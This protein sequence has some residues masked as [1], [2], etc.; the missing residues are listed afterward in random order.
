MATHSPN[1][2][3][4]AIVSS[5][6]KSGTEIPTC[7]IPSAGTAGVVVSGRSGS[8]SPRRPQA[9]M[10]KVSSSMLVTVLRVLRI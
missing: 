3:Q 2:P 7:P 1:G 8:T 4:N 5:A 6:K 10:N 9:S